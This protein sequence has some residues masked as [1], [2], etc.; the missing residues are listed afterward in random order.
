MWTGKQYIL[1]SA[2]FTVL[3]TKLLDSTHTM[4]YSVTRKTKKLKQKLG[5]KALLD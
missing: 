5:M 4:D 3:R 1:T 2:P